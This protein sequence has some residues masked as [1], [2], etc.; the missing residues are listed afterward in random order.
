MS[1]NLFK[2]ITKEDPM[3]SI[4]EPLDKIINDYCKWYNNCT[5]EF[6]LS[7]KQIGFSASWGFEIEDND[8][9]KKASNLPK[10]YI[11]NSDFYIV[12]LPLTRGLIC[13]EST[14]QFVYFEFEYGAFEKYFLSK[15]E[16]NPYKYILIPFDKITDVTLDV[17]SNQIFYS[18]IKSKNVVS[19]S[20]VGGIIAGAPG[21]IIGGTTG[22]KESIT[23]QK[24]KPKNISLKISTSLK[25]NPTILF[26]FRISPYSENGNLFDFGIIDTFLCTFSKENFEKSK[27][28]YPLLNRLAFNDLSN[29][30]SHPAFVLYKNES[31]IFELKVVS[32]SVL[33]TLEE[34]YNKIYD[35][36]QSQQKKIQFNNDQTDIIETIKKLSE[37][38]DIGIITQ[39]EFDTKKA[40]L[41]SKL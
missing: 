35:I 36:I 12:D 37:L 20:I 26:K 30:Y 1:F 2:K 40:E 17:D 23:T 25:E 7:L 32:D 22:T 27:Y 41:L 16:I 11:P 19:R 21:A 18:N 10:L 13:D 34:Y 38:K 8:R 39:K 24:L 28:I 33:K 29:K 9:V 14:N 15:S 5:K 6:V 3:Q 31:H 4:I